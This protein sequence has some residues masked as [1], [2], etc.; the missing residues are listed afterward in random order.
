MRRQPSDRNNKVHH[1]VHFIGPNKY[2][3][4]V[5]EYLAFFPW[6]RVLILL[7]I[8]DALE[9]RFRNNNPPVHA[10]TC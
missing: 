2:G 9:Y 1:P 6:H 8:Y 3:R 4:D 5:V 7:R 10:S